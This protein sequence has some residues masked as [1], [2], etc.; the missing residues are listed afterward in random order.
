M[1]FF[2]DM[3]VLRTFQTQASVM[4]RD[5][6]WWLHTVVPKMFKVNQQEF[7]Q[8]Y[9]LKIVLAFFTFLVHMMSLGSA[10]SCRD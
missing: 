9:D 8:W 1:F 3:D 2:V 6:V 7:N 10:L 5:A 4:Q